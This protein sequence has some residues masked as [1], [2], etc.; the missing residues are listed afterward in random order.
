MSTDSEKTIEIQPSVGAVVE[1]FAGTVWMTVSGDEVPPL[2]PPDDPPD[3]P[4]LDPPPA[5]GF[6]LVESLPPPQPASV[7]LTRIP[8][9][10]VRQPLPR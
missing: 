1:P 8:T 7:A 2:E 10:P 9:R 5:T 6:D 4:P 3:E